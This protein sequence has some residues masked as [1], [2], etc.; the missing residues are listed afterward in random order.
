MKIISCLYE[1]I[2]YT[3][4]RLMNIKLLHGHE[5]RLES[6]KKDIHELW[7]Q[8]FTKTPVINTKLIL[9]TGIAGM[10]QNQ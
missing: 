1:V 8:T 2:S 9:T 3:N 5:K 7:I 4:L 10:Q 6:Y